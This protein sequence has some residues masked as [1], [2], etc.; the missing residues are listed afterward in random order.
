MIELRDID[1]QHSGWSE[2]SRQDMTSWDMPL[3]ITPVTFS[4]SDWQMRHVELRMF[5]IICI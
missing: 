5:S 1:E 2:D 3:F 4:D